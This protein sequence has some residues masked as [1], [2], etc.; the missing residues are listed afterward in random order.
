MTE[1]F[2]RQFADHWLA[3]WNAHNLDAVLS[4]YAPDFEMSSPLIAAMGINPSGTL[5]GKDAVAAYWRAALDRLPD[6]R[7][8]PIAV[9]A[10]AAS[11]VIHYRTSFGKLA[12]ETFV[13]DQQDKVIR[14]A[15]H[16]AA[17]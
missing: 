14:A 17:D 8:E 5:R 16:Y 7:F 4:H 13:F 10:G 3:A 1:A 15:A 2:A 12:A 11:L 9:L 6:L